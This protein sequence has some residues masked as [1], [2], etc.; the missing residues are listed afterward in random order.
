[1]K[2][3]YYDG[4]PVPLIADRMARTTD[5]IYQLLSRTHRALRT[6]VEVETNGAG[7]EV[8]STLK[9]RSQEGQS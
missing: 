6:C 9:S 5:A 4:L 1:M 3:R 8:E 2:L 7:G